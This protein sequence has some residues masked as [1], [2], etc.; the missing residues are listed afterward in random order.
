MT[1][2]LVKLDR[3][4]R[5]LAEGLTYSVPEE[6]VGTLAIGSLVKVPLK[7]EITTGAVVGIG[8]K[9]PTFAVRP[10]T[11]LLDDDL[12]PVLRTEQLALIEWLAEYYLTPWAHAFAVVLPQASR[13]RSRKNNSS[14]DSAKEVPPTSHY[15]PLHTLTTAQ[16]QALDDIIL[17]F[18]SPESRPV[19]LHGVTGSGKTEIYMH[20]I[21]DQLKQS[22]S[23]LVLVPEITLT[24][25]L[26][27]RFR[28]RFGDKVVVLHSGM[29]NS[30][31]KQNW[32]MIRTGQARIVVGARSAVFAPLR[33]L[34]LIILDEEHE[35]TF[36][37][38]EDPKYH[39]RDVAIWRGNYNGARILLGSAT[40]SL[41]SFYLACNEKYKLV[42]LGERIHARP[43]AAIELVDMRREL[44]EGNRSL[45]SRMLLR[46]LE[47][48]V[49]RGEQ[50]ILFHN[51]RGFH[52]MTLCRSCGFVL[53]CPEC[54]VPLIEHKDSGHQTVSGQHRQE[55]HLK[56]HICDYEIEMPDKC[57]Q[58]G[59]GYLRF[60]G[61]GTEK[62]VE[63]CAKAFPQ[64]RI[65]RLDA[66]SSRQRDAKTEIVRSFGNH[67]AEIL[68]GTQMVA[69]GL[70]FPAVT[71]VGIISADSIL[72]AP[73]YRATEQAYSLMTQVSGRSGRG[74]HP[75]RVIIQSYAPEH[76]LVQAV[77][78]QSY[79]AFYNTEIPR[80]EK[81]FEPP[82]S[83]LAWV[84]ASAL[85]P[86]DAFRCMYLW[87]TEIDPGCE[88]RGPQPARLYRQSGRFRYQLI[89]KADSRQRLKDALRSLSEKHPPGK[90]IQLSI[91]LDPLRM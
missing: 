8:E 57:P 83:F 90:N 31:R 34:G 36:K 41:E 86:Q 1:Y 45:F 50:A 74:D 7:N 87:S 4:V 26:M 69:K 40:P 54:E 10:I 37:S 21:E 17:E 72:R 66:D 48:I 16:Q 67:Q 81:H 71:L 89:L 32:R 76:P 9:E 68:V 3:P 28:N 15:Q 39:A 42:S 25:Q 2:A 70:D 33:E 73:D 19:L 30:A 43:M 64:A 29:T 84:T 63:E 44:Q 20:L 91:T 62:V 79:Q 58:C 49:S 22:H 11:A 14:A 47:G 5:E 24:V 18:N 77:R 12:G 80:R 56:C 38:E 82:F 78:S 35:H 52:R 75:G 23:C 59:S 53:E 61:I 51:Q 65:L 13:G 55:S 46:D 27:D 60:F 88:V 6:M 85:T